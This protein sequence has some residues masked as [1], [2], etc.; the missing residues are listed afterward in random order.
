M[1]PRSGAPTLRGTIQHHPA[2]ADNA[3]QARPAE[4]PAD[5]A[6]KPGFGSDWDSSSRQTS[7][8]RAH[9]HMKRDSRLTRSADHRALLPASAVHSTQNPQIRI[10]NALTGINPMPAHNGGQYAP[11]SSSQDSLAISFL[12]PRPD[13]S[14]KYSLRPGAVNVRFCR[15]AGRC[16]GDFL[17]NRRGFGGDSTKPGRSNVFVLATQSERV[18]ALRPEPESAGR[19]ALIRATALSD[20]L[21]ASAVVLGRWV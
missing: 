15:R 18:P 13:E 20:S 4:P 9:Q 10:N 8:M 3:P 19:R 5:V 21:G 11:A 1:S 6:G 17:V 7:L 14:H 2:P 12:L 16:P